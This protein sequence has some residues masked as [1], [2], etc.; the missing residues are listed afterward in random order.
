MGGTGILGALLAAGCAMLA[1]PNVQFYWLAYLFPIPLWIA[2]SKA[3]SWKRAALIGWLFGT[4]FMGYIHSWILY[5][6]PWASIWALIGAWAVFSLYLGL[7]YA[8][9]FGVSYFLKNTSFSW[10]TI[11]VVWVVFEWLRGL[12]SFGS[13]GGVIGYSQSAYPIV[14]QLAFYTGT[15]GISLFC[16]I[17]SYLLFQA[18]YNRRYIPLAGAGILISIVF[19]IGF[20]RLMPPDIAPNLPNVAIIQGNHPQTMKLQA[21]NYS[22]I[23]KDYIILTKLAMRSSPDLVI[24]PE[25]FVPKLNLRDTKLM[26]DI[27]NLTQRFDAT[28]LFGTPIFHNK[29]YYNTAVA[30]LPSGMMPPPVIKQRLM[31]FGEYLP[32]RNLIKKLGIP[33]PNWMGN[34]Y[35]ART[36]PPKLL[37]TGMHKIGIAICLESTRAKHFNS[38]SKQGAEFFVVLG[39]NAWFK[40]SIAAPLHLQTSIMRAVETNRPVIHAA[41]T[42][43]SAI[44]SSK[45]YVISQSRLD[46]RIILTP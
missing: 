9:T 18:V 27:K 3:K 10:I 44:I 40:D 31:P 23:Y 12:G 29:H 33:I 41:N 30:I 32:C 38:L 46:E 22:T 28:I 36:T 7:Y 16:L 8:A 26:T 5:L 6:T 24:W 20:V 35:T 1:F 19:T 45:G 39:N 13:V 14:R 17:I 21:A 4:L 34:D 37:D 43:I 2:L 15:F 11:P 25:T 42:G